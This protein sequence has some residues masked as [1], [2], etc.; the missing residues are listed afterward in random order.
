MCLSH[1]VLSTL[2]GLELVCREEPNQGVQ[3]EIDLFG[4]RVRVGFY[5]TFAS[6]SAADAVQCVGLPDLVEVSRDEDTGQVHA[7][8][9]TAF[10]SMQFHAESV[11]SP[12][13]LAIVT[14]MLQELLVPVEEDHASAS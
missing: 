14:E 12:D 2:L 11:L 5:N 4:R 3:C 13:G 7:L 6:R 1:Q 8:R 9:S 10:R